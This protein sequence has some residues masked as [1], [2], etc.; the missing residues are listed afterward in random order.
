MKK[1]NFTL[2]ELLVVIGILAILA[3]LIIPAVS[4]AKL[5]GRITQARTDMA[6]L[7]TAFE[8]MYRDYGRMAQ[9]SG[10]NYTLGG[11]SFSENP[12]NSGCITIHEAT[13]T[14]AYCNIIGE[15][16]V[17]ASITP[18]L[19]TRNIKYLDPRPEYDPSHPPTYSSGA[20]DNPSH[21]WLDPWGHPYQIRINVDASE[22]I[23]DPSNT[24][25]RLSGRIIFW[26][27]GP[28]GASGED[29][30]TGNSGTSATDRENAKDNIASWKDGDWFD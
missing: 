11:Q 24:N 20:V 19:N 25:R 27:F 21:T 2:V 1:R 17:P 7:R 5:K 14:N 13:A 18:S 4:S 22:Q 28:D 29:S 16:S 15:L 8:G 6:S 9:S 26:S 12:N 10:S 30:Q 23:V 3:G